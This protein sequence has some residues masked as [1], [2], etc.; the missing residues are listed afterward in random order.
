MNGKLDKI[1]LLIRYLKIYFISC[2]NYARSAQNNCSSW[3]ISLFKIELF[4]IVLLQCHEDTIILCTH[5]VT[6]WT[7]GG[8]KKKKYWV[9]FTECCNAKEFVFSVF[10]CPTQSI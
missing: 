10:R 3:E 6:V 7:S 4:N 8:K 1:Q 5:S 9:V 2:K